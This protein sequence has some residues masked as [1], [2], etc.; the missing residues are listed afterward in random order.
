MKKNFCKRK[1]RK[2]ESIPRSGC[3][4]C[5]THQIARGIMGGTRCKRGVD[6]YA[7]RFGWCV[8]P[9][10]L[11][12][13]CTRFLQKQKRKKWLTGVTERQQERRN[14]RCIGALAFA[15]AYVFY[16]EKTFGPSADRD[17]KH[18]HLHRP[19]FSFFH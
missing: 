17:R 11:L 15:S 18:I 7:E 14:E 9:L 6:R 12:A 4:A 5:L 19:E 13:F 10:S 1:K 16:Q 8:G 3:A 2:K